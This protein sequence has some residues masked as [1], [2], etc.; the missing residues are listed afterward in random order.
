[1][2]CVF[3]AGI[4]A[5]E[6][7]QP[8]KKEDTSKEQKAE[9]KNI[10]N[11]DIQ[12]TDAENISIPVADFKRQ[13]DRYRIGFQD[14][15]QITVARHSDLNQTISVGS[16]GT[17]L[18]PR[19]SE[20][21]VAVC[22]TEAELAA[23]ITELYKKD[24][25]RNPY[26]NV[27]ILEQRS[28]PFAVIGAVNK[29]GN[30]FGTQRIRLL[31]LLALAGGQ[32]VENAGSRVQVARVGNFASCNPTD[33]S[34]EDVQFFSYN[35][36]DVLTGR[37]NPWM[38]PGDI[39]SVLEAEE[40]YVVGDVVEP[41]TVKLKEPVTLTEAIAQAKGLNDTAK[42]SEV[43]VHRKEKGNPIRTE[44]TFN[45]KEIRDKKVA[46]PVLQGN[47]IVEI[48]TSGSKVFKKGLWDIIKNS[49]PSIFYRLP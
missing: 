33:Q 2:V 24:Y 38:Q 9:N 32:D 34:D 17:I 11:N 26:V 6:T 3:T 43:V 19:I 27:R 42:I 49:V 20:P 37:E 4:T 35:I 22:K 46:D 47:D 30:F 48:S 28:Q 16:D 21:I 45:L 14:I 29:P 1:M 5:Q 12:A 15:L 7:I 41:T 25:L 18:L 36:N 40:A 44:L 23:L 13:N 39:V 10:K 31:T 8:D